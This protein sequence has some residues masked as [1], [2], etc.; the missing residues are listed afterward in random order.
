MP[1]FIELREDF[2][3]NFLGKIERKILRKEELEKYQAG[4]S[5]KTGG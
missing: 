1:E 2:P 3:R 4:Q 5:A